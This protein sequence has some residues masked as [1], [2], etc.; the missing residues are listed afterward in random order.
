ML[1]YVLWTY[2]I[3]TSFAIKTT[4][5]H[6]ILVSYTTRGLKLGFW[7]AWKLPQLDDRKWPNIEIWGHL[8]SFNPG[9]LTRP[10]IQVWGRAGYTCDEPQFV[11]FQVSIDTYVREPKI[12]Q[13]RKKFLQKM[14]NY[15]KIDKPSDKNQQKLKNGK[16]QKKIEK[17]L[18]N[19]FCERGIL[20]L[21]L[22]NI[23][24]R[25]RITI[26]VFES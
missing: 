1:F 14:T 16:N 19:V 7:T 10:K 23:C 24:F 5:T 8:R 18:T 13:K 25:G 12:W 17:N 2:H 26:G 6:R 11:P 22:K 15:W 21:F 4:T 20:V 9:V 3:V